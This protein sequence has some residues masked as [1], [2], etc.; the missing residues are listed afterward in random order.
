MIFE[1][2]VKIIAL[3]IN[4]NPI[5]QIEGKVSSG[6]AINIDGSSAVRRTCSLT[7]L[8]DQEDTKITNEYWGLSHK[9]KLEIGFLNEIDSKYPKI[10]WIN[11]GIFVISSFNVSES[12]NNYTVSI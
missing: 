12:I 11:Q 8:V 1:K 3:D 4:E 6:G 5:E 2:Y 10:I 7:L 9:F